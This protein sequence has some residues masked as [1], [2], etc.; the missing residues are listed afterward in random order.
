MNLTANQVGTEGLDT[1]YHCLDINRHLSGLVTSANISDIISW[2]KQIRFLMFSEAAIHRH[3][4]KEQKQS[5]I[6]HLL[7]STL[8]VSKTPY[9]IEQRSTQT[10]IYAWTAHN[11]F[12]QT[13]YKLQKIWHWKKIRKV[14][15][16]EQTIKAE[17]RNTTKNQPRHT[18]TERSGI[19]KNSKS[20]IY[21]S[22]NQIR[23]QKR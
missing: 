13:D 19:E 10:W 23:T 20:R 7:D 1:P 17:P 4:G 6:V 5:L 12:G 8:I 9:L 21:R 18:V 14:G 11:I 22:N 2:K 3:M 15:F 16:K